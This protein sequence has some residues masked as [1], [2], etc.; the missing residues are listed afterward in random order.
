MSYREPMRVW[1][2]LASY[3]KE[4]T[5]NQSGLRLHIYD[6]GPQCAPVLLLVHGL[7]DESDSWRHIIQPLSIHQRVIAPD[8]PGFGRSEPLQRYAI[9][10]IIHVLLDLLDTLNIPSAT[11]IGSS[12]GGLLSHAIAI[13]HPDRVRGLVLI[14]G[15][16]AANKQKLNLGTLLFM[17]PGIGEWLYNRYRKNP[18]AAYDSLIPFYAN[19]ENLPAADREFLFQ[20]VNERVWSNRQR[21]AYLA[22]LRNT[23]FWMVA[24]QRNLKENLKMLTVP[25]L[26]IFGEQDHIMPLENAYVLPELQST[27]QLITLPGVGHLPQQEAPAALLRIL[28]NDPRLHI[29]L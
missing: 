19:L 22:I 23:A 11:L 20:R 13:E 3:T 25:T 27:A 4:I 5:L 12:L 8:L 15:H 6:A 7:G 10:E 26:V 9:A 29:Q 1:P 16:L 14:D 17:V 24:Q 2:T 21:K 18:Q 28:Q